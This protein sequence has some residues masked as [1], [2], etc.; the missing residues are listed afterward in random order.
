MGFD[1]SAW[2]YFVSSDHRTGEDLEF[3]KVY[4]K[5]INFEKLLD[6]ASG[7][8]HFANI[9]NAKLKV[10]S[11]LSLNMLK[12]ARKQYRFRHLVRCDATVLPF[13]DR[14]FDIITC[15]IAFHH[16]QMPSE[17]FKESSR[18]LK[19]KGFLVLIDSIVDIDD[20]ELNKIEKIRDNTHY[21]S[22]TVNEILSFAK[23]FRLLS[24]HTIFKKHN[25]E[26]WAKRLSPTEDKFKMIEKAFLE[27]N[28]E[29]K[30]ELKLEIENGKVISY[31]D[32]KGIFIFQ[33]LAG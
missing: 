24:F 11:D 1:E 10:I 3:I 30:R 26:E 4:F 8:G 27:L 13:K 6:V 15:R 20:D 7:A 19:P 5:G 33:S 9:F 21:R 32:K 29:I 28:E 17:F 14:S 2:N 22:H 31:T 23:N 25:F 16:F 18:V 12:T